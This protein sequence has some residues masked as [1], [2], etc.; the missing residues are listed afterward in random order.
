MSNFTILMYEDEVEYKESFEYSIKA[1]ITAKGRVL[2]LHHR[3]DGD[4]IE[5][6]LMM[7][8]PDLIM[9]DHDL[10]ETTGD[11][12]IGIIDGMPEF[13]KTSIYYYSGGESLEELQKRTKKF[14]CQIQCFTKSGD[15]LDGAVLGLAGG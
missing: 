1:K 14:K 3:Q 10:G 5:Q 11:E 15:E 12:I 6:D 8:N 4:T 13:A 9:V 7:Y 2:R